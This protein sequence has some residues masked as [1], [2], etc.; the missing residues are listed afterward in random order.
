MSPTTLA[1]GQS[2]HD[3]AEV[4]SRAF[5]TGDTS[6]LEILKRCPIS[7]LHSDTTN[8]PTVDAITVDLIELLFRLDM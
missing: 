4:K 7:H 8:P 5:S 2:Q 1:G 3:L 6:G